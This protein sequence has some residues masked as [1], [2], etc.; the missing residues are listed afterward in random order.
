M[1]F[2]LETIEQKVKET[3]IN[4]LNIT[5]EEYSPDAA[6]IDD[7]GA[8]SLDIVEM[9]MSMEDI[10]GIEIDDE[11]LEKIRYVKDVIDYLKKR[12]SA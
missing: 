2:D 3:I 6:F 10:F 1:A 11:D 7:L 8:D 5:D 9:I 12:L 4:Q